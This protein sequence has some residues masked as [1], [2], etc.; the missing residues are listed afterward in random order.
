MRPGPGR[1][2]RRRK[3]AS[4]VLDRCTF[5]EIYPEVEYNPNIPRSFAVPYIH[6]L[7]SSQRPIIYACLLTREEITP[8]DITPQAP[9]K[10]APHPEIRG[11]ELTASGTLLSCYIRTVPAPSTTTRFPTFLFLLIPNHPRA[12]SSEGDREEEA[13]K[14]A[15]RKPAKCI[16]YIHRLR[17]GTGE[18]ARRPRGSDTTHTTLSSLRLSDCRATP[19]LQGSQSTDSESQC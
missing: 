14:E 3:G 1:C 16:I 6:G 18:A 10:L 17:T 4:L 5:I 11:P 2:T 15:R 8:R 13:R 19:P 12:I 7:P 9:A